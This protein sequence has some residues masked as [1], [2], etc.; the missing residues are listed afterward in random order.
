M[1]DTPDNM[2]ATVAYPSCESENVETLPGAGTDRD[3][4]YRALLRTTHGVGIVR[5]WF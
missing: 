1:R 4:E 2:T 5:Y 3:S